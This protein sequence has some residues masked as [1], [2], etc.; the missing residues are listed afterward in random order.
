ME[1]AQIIDLWKRFFRG[2]LNSGEKEVLAQWIEES[3]EEADLDNLLEMTWQ[4]FDY[5]DRVPEESAREMLSNIQAGIKNVKQVST[6]V[7]MKRRLPGFLVAAS[8][9]FILGVA[10]YLLLF[11][12]PVKS[13][14]V[15]GQVT[16]AK[17]VQAPA[18]NKAMITLADGSTI[19]LD[20]LKTGVLVLPGNIKLIKLADGKIVYDLGDGTVSGSMQ[21]NT[22]VNPKGSKVLEIALSDGSHVWLNTGSSITY[23]VVFLGNERRVNIN[24]EAYFEVSHDTKKPFFVSKGNMGVRVLGTHF[25][26]H[27]YDDESNMAVTLLEGSVE[28]SNEKSK[29]IIKPGQQA[30]V[31]QGSGM[32]DNRTVSLDQVMAWK[33]GLF[34]FNHDDLKSVMNELERWYDVDVEYDK[35]I[36]EMEFGGELQRN[37][38][39]SQVLKALEKSNVHFRIVG[40]KIIVLR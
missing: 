35:A 16:K 14:Q 34:S 29:L 4:A 20:S 38:N 21:Y 32:I 9:I 37:L 5:S 23:P 24:G 1:D 15:A 6:V 3:A 22:I 18:T 8:L 2:D 39:L 13:D 30:I 10:L 33:Y 26:I 12:K 27:A 25:N 40:R 7:L 31:T 28:V 36:P 17:D 11:H 19:A